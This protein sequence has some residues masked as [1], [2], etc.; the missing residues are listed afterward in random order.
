MVLHSI[1]YQTIQKVLHPLL[2]SEHPQCAPTSKDDSNVASQELSLGDGSDDDSNETKAKSH[3][4]EKDKETYE[5]KDDVTIAAVEWTKDD[6]KNV[7]DLGS[8]EL[9]R[10]HRLESL[11]LKRRARKNIRFLTGNNPKGTDYLTSMFSLDSAESRDVI[12]NAVWGGKKGIDKLESSDEN[13][14]EV[15]EA[16]EIDESLLSELDAVGDFHAEEITPDQLGFELMMSSDI[17]SDCLYLPKRRPKKIQSDLLVLRAKS[18]EDIEESAKHLKA[19][20]LRVGPG[21]DIRESCS[22]VE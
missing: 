21:D 8:F 1:L 17:S 13:H 12:Q 20:V 22:R 3:E 7:M 18:L 5:E 9:E 15:L 6:Q 10:S 11:I 16:T 14:P 2:G 4:N 19:E